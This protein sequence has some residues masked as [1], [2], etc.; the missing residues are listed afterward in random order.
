MKRWI[1][2]LVA[3][4]AMVLLTL[5]PQAA[6]KGVQAGLSLCAGTVIPS[7]FPFFVVISLLLQL[8]LADSLQGVCGPIMGPLFH[9]RGACALPLLAGLLGGYPSGARTAAGM[10]AQGR[11]T[12][13]EA[14]TL[15]GF[16]DN[17][18]PGFLLGYAGAAVLGEARLGAALCVVH[19][20]S[21]LITGMILCRVRRQRGTP[22]ALPHGG[23]GAVPFAQALTAS[24]RGAVESTL[25]VCAFVVLFQTLAALLPGELPWYALGALE[26]VSGLSVLPGGR[27]GFAAAAVLAGWGGVSVHCQALAVTAPEGLS[28]RAHWGGKALQ[29]GVSAL[30]AAGALC[31]L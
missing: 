5:Q 19:I 23:N 12:R 14:E 10:Y 20:L 11:L 15:L 30:L 26:M 7:L 4:A 17:C 31:F 16:C 25:N 27:A 21:A 18:G 13:Q 3:L 6:S 2:L 1:P 8:G 24:A 28:F 22:H 29:A 9:M